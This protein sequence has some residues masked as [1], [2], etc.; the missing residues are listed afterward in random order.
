MYIPGLPFEL[1][2]LEPSQSFSKELQKVLRY[3]S[4]MMI[5]IKQC[6]NYEDT[7]GLILRETSFIH[8]SSFIYMKFI[9]NINIESKTFLKLANV[10]SSKCLP[11]FTVKMKDI[12]N[13]KI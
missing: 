1:P 9:Q 5:D 6:Q 2:F 7:F 10:S 11:D 4:V 12:E 8:V 3:F 13:K